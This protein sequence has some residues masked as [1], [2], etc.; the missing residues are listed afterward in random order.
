MKIKVA[1][2]NK[3]L[4]HDLINNITL[5]SIHSLTDFDVVIIDPKGFSSIWT[6]PA[7]LGKIN[8][9][10]AGIYFT[11]ARSDHG[12]GMQIFNIFSKRREEIKKL[13]S[14][15]QGIVICYLRSSED[16][17]NITHALYGN[18][19]REVLNIYSWL[20]QFDLERIEA[21]IIFYEHFPKNINFIGRV[22]KEIPFIEQSHPFSKY[23]YAFKNQIHFEC[24]I[25]P[26]KKMR[27]LLKAIAGNKVKEIISCEINI[28]RGK[29][30]FIPPTISTDLKKETGVL[31][32]CIEGVF[33]H[34]IETPPPPWI[35]KYSLPN[36]NKNVA[37]LEQLNKKI[38]GFQ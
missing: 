11:D 10:T 5:D 1:S 7:S 35:I 3:N 26:L 29:I 2:V 30:I 19:T 28:G 33:E 17:L 25:E 38:S 36:E 16:I 14:V 18:V 21:G 37:K 4:E 27:K 15:S 13:L 22:G 32:D 31:L 20:P 8:R 12:I 9:D 34:G 6:T 24:I 23:F